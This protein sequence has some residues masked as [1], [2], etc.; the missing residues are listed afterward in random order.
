MDY[1]K[2]L[3]VNT[4]WLM[5][6]Y[7]SPLKDDGY[8]ISNYYDINPIYGTLDDF[9]LFLKKA[10]RLGLKVI[11]EL[12]LN[13]TSD[14]HSWF[15][16]ARR[17][18]PNS[19]E[20]DFYVW[21]DT[22]N[23]YTDARIIFPDFETSN[24]AWDH[25][26]NAY[27][28]HRFYSHQP[29]LNYA[30]PH[31]QQA[32]LD[33]VDFWLDIG[34][35]GFRLDAVSYLF[36]REGTNCENLPETHDFLC[37]LRAHIDDR[38][39]N[40]VLLAEVN[41]WAEDAVAYFGN[42]KECHMCFHFPLMPRMFMA[43]EKEDRFPITD[44][45]GQAP[46]IPHNAQWATF[47]RNHDELTL[48]MVTDED[49]DFMYN[50]FASES[51]AKINV[52]IRRRL[53]PL[54]GNN[55]KKIELLN[56][57]LFFLPGAPIIYYG[58]EI[59]MGDNI[60]LGDRNGVRTPLQWS[61]DR[62]AGF[63]KA[64]NQQLYFP[65]IVDHEYHYEAI[66]IE[67]QKANI[68][69]LLWWMKKLISLRKNS[70]P[71]SQ[72]IVKILHPRN[73]KVLVLLRVYEQQICLLVANLS[74][75][76]EFV[77]ID[78]SEFKGSIPA[79]MFGGTE[80]PIITEKPVVFTL[81][82]HQSYLFELVNRSNNSSATAIIDNNNIVVDDT[83]CI[84]QNELFYE[85][86]SEILPN[87]L[88]CAIWFKEDIKEISKIELSPLPI[89][90][91]ISEPCV[92]LRITISYQRR[93]SDMHLLPL[94]YLTGEKSSPLYAEYP[95]S[96][97][98]KLLNTK[99][100]PL[101]MLFDAVVV[102]EFRFSLLKWI[103]DSAKINS[104][105]YFSWKGKKIDIDFENKEVEKSLLCYR[106]NSTMVFDGELVLRLLYKIE[107]GTH[108]EVELGAFLESEQETPAV[109][110]FIGVLNLK[111]DH[112]D[113]RSAI[114][115]HQYVSNIRNFHDY[116]LD[117]LSRFYERISLYIQESSLGDVNE[118]T[119]ELSSAYFM[120]IE[121]LGKR[122]GEFHSILSKSNTTPL[123][124]Q[125]KIGDFELK[126][127][128]KAFRE[129]FMRSFISVEEKAS[130]LCQKEDSAELEIVAA[131]VKTKEIVLECTERLLINKMSG[132]KI[133]IHGDLSLELI[134]F[135]G[136]DF[137]ILDFEGNHN[138]PLSTRKLRKHPFVDLAILINSII[139][140]SEQ[141]LR[142]RNIS[143][144]DQKLIIPWKNSWLLCCVQSLLE[145]YWVCFEKLDPRK[146]EN[147]VAHH[148][149]LFLFIADHLLMSL[150]E[151]L[152]DKDT[153]DIKITMELINLFFAYFTLSKQQE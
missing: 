50:I 18:P 148:N 149:L 152:K 81:A 127:L 129:K 51:K 54:L 84:F 73:H 35:D 102:S 89:D 14:Q 22:P 55:R 85:K 130:V 66:N 39:P 77:E 107:K 141:A 52:G 25:V 61:G 49:R 122:I 78:L 27:Y 9:K 82:S 100:D 113:I 144:T 44:I 153:N 93:G 108:P 42:G 58:D 128:Y 115:V 83:S 99:G 140:V 121:L 92:L 118:K 94:I 60:Y 29:D 80:F 3:G 116:T 86:L 114:L 91:E 16:S 1:L 28:W 65:V 123:F 143:L 46:E 5:P 47:L 119:K 23:K 147:C 98:A 74:R 139:K 101:G 12:V 8:D 125:E 57:I 68:N 124:A 38:Y 19:S 4:I 135:T 150:V 151:D 62:N 142:L 20:R 53:A 104:N 146:N 106:H 10:H 132:F 76:V 75:H 97:V 110:P 79:E 31:V 40:R 15:Q 56:S 103:A 133:R 70:L 137:V 72:G 36:E 120:G 105:K 96:A 24:W 17:A 134:L 64:L 33:V 90:L 43:V 21:S 30:N 67:N 71:L 59:G 7:P 95:R 63:S 145:G 34:I 32:M 45:L 37:R 88:R 69:S 41:Q 117:E 109:A 13:H 87:Y 26:A 2:E 111:V 11:T 136:R 48:E 131:I 126:S 6:F 138:R 112:L